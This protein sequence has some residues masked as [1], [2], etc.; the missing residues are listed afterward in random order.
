M[1]KEEIIALQKE[2]G[3]KADGVI[4]PVTRAAAQAKIN[5]QAVLLN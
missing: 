3:V 1:T 4:G 5:E 2:L